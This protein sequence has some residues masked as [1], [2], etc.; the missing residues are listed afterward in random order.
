[1]SI[2][3]T[4][5]QPQPTPPQ[6]IYVAPP[7]TNSLATGSMVVGIVSIPLLFCCYI[8]VVTGVVAAVLGVIA[9][10]KANK[11]GGIGKSYAWVG[12]ACGA[13]P[14]VLGLIF[15]VF[16]FAGSMIQGVNP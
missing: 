14:L 8:G 12:I 2:D 1:M 6:I 16:G 15:M 11:T 13:A 4:N 5:P 7:A 9:L 3:P 10:D